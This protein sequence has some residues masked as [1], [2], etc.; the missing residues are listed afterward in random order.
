MNPFEKASETVKEFV[1]SV[2]NLC[3]K[4][5]CPVSTRQ[6]FLYGLAKT[7]KKKSPIPLRPVLSATACY[8]FQLA[9][10]ISK[11]ISPFCYSKFGLGNV[12]EFLRRLKIKDQRRSSGRC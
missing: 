4:V 2:P 3:E 10:F 9:K 11:A 7:H 5:D 12:D 1:N 8:N 6:P